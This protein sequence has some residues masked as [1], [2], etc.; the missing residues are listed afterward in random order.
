LQREV[1]SIW[2]ASNGRSGSR[3]LNQLTAASIIA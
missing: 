3:F 2:N 1:T